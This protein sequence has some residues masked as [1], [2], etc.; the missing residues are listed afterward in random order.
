[1][2]RK[3]K[4]IAFDMDGTLLEGRVIQVLAERHGFTEDFVKIQKDSILQGYQKSE[5][6]ALLL[7]GIHQDDI[8][9]AVS[10]LKIV[11]NWRETIEELKQQEHILGIISDSYK[12][13]CDYLAKKMNL[14]FVIANK[15]DTDRKRVLT[16]RISMPLGWQKI[17][18]KC[19]ISVC[20]RY[21][22][23]KISEK[24]KIPLSDTVVVGDT[25]SDLCMIERAGTGIAWMPK[26]RILEEKADIVIKTCDLRKIIP[27][28]L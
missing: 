20:K 4:L 11:K 19:K 21:H 13:A 1:M 24:F 26:D 7:K 10:D 2:Q 22:L 12:V 23:E 9:K 6:I 5:K 25:I 14:D 16:G 18:C 28:V 27:F 17:D 15:L 3:R 8:V